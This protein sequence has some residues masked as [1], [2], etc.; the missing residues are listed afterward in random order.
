MLDIKLE[1]EDLAASLIAEAASKDARTGARALRPI[2]VELINPFEFD[3]LHKGELE[4]L[5]GGG[6]KLLV[7]ADMVRKVLK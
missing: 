4:P 6:W 5:E 2:F 3:P 1:I 7:T